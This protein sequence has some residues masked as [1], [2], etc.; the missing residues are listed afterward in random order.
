MNKSERKNCESCIEIVQYENFFIVSK[1]FP[2]RWE[3]ESL[4]EF[5]SRNHSSKTMQRCPI[6]F[7][8]ESDRFCMQATHLCRPD[9]N[10]MYLFS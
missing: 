6:T 4:F 5:L 8:E 9:W 3:C 2:F 1:N 10:V 7:R